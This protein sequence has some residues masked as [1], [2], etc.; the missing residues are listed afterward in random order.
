MRFGR[1]SPKK[2]PNVPASEIEKH[3]WGVFLGETRWKFYQTEKSAAK[4]VLDNSP[5]TA[6]LANEI[7][8]LA[9]A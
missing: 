5:A 3:K 6:E 8:K 7:R 2:N 4:F 1:S 9:E